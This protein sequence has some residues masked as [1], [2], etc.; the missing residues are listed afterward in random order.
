V[1][2]W[3]ETAGSAATEC[4]LDYDTTANFA[5]KL[6]V[7]F[8]HQST[9]RKRFTVSQEKHDIEKPRGLKRPTQ[10]RATYV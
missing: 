5:S 2:S 8:I 9:S 6:F 10:G 4:K 3:P 7:Y 1:S